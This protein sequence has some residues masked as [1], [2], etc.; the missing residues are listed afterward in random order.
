M[1]LDILDLDI[2]DLDM[3]DMDTHMLDMAE[4]DIWE[5][6]R[7][8]QQL[9]QRPRLIPTFFME[10]IMVATLDMLD[11]PDMDTLDM[12]DMDIATLVKQHQTT[13]YPATENGLNYHHCFLLQ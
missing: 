13:L 6:V 5:S 10:V 11:T 4:L 12:P 3:P 9:N 1:D 7:L 2:L 8:N